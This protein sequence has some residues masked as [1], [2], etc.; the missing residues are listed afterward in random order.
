MSTDADS[1]YTII[2]QHAIYGNF[3]APKVQEI[4]VARGEVLELLRP[5]DNGRVQTVHSTHVFGIIRSLQAFRFPGSHE[6]YIIVGSDSGR[7]VILKFSAEKNM[8]L[9]IHQETFGKSGCRRIVPGEYL[10]VDPKGRACLIGALEKQKFVYVLNRDSDAQLTISSPLDA[11]KSYHIVFDIVG[12]DMGFDNPQF[13]AIELDYGEVDVDPTGEAAAEATKQLVIY[14]LDLGLNS[15]TRKSA[16]DIDSGAN[17][18][19]PVPG[20]ADGGPGGVLVCCENFLL[21][22]NA[23][24]PEL[25]A[26]IPRRA[27]LPLDKSVLITA[28]ATLK[29][30]SRFFTFLQTEYGDL[31][32]VTMTYDGSTVTELKMKYFDT[33]PPATSI[34]ILRK[35]FLFAASEFGDHYLY[36]FEGLGDDEDAVESSSHNVKLEN[37]MSED[38]PKYH[39]MR[40]EP[41]FPLR[42]L[43]QIDTISSVSPVIDMKV[44]N[45]LKEETPQIYCACGRGTRSS[46]RVLRPGLSVTEVASSVLKANAT[47]VFTMK[48][49]MEDEYDTYVVVSF[50]HSTLIL[51]VGETVEPT[52]ETGFDEETQTLGAQHMH[53][54]SLSQITPTGI[55]H[56]KQSGQV[57]EWKAPERRNVTKVASN[58]RQVAIALAGGEVL[59]FEMT[60]QG[61]LIETER[62][63][64][65]GDVSSLSLGD[66][67][68][69]SLRNRYLAVGSYD[70]TVR[71]LSLDPGDG[72]KSLN[73]QML[74]DTPESLL[75]LDESEHHA[76]LHLQIGLANG[77]LQRTDVDR[78][79]GEM[80]DS[81]TRFLGAKQ[82]TLCRVNVAGKKSMLA[83]SSRPWIGYTDQGKYSIAPISYESLNY[84]APFSTEQCPE[85]FV[86]VT[87]NSLRVISIDRL[88]QFFNELSIPL[89]YTPRKLIIHPD[90]STLVTIESDTQMKNYTSSDG[91]SSMDVDGEADKMNQIGSYQGTRGEWASCIRIVDPST[92]T[93]LHSVELDENEAAISAAIAEFD[94]AP[95]RGLLLCV[96]TTKGLSFNPRRSEGNYIRTYAFAEDGKS[97]SLIHKTEV[98]AIPRALVQFKGKLLAG[99]GASV[100][101][102]DVGKKRLLRKCEY[103]S[104]PT[105]V[106]TLHTTGSRIYVGDAYE[107]V[108]FMKYKK[109]ENKLYIFADDSI[110]RHITAVCPLD[111]DTVAA[112]DKFGNLTVLRLPPEL[113]AAVEEDPT[114]GKYAGDISTGAPN[115]LQSIANFHVGEIITSIQRSTLQDHGKE[116]MLYTTLN[117]TVGAVHAFSS[118]DSIDFF[119]HLEMHMRQE[120]P[121]L[122][123]RDHL[124]FRSAYIPVK[125]VVDGDLCSQFGRLPIDTQK[126]VA[127][128]LDRTPTEVLKKIEDTMNLIV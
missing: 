7:I 64:L 11:H 79:T 102:F 14:E 3:S 20:L 49:N 81:R 61:N 115:K 9:K 16:E 29:Q 22:R 100:K 68:E 10:A 75:L 70:K 74:S 76:S 41:R 95:D 122:L 113:S 82:P 44:A 87:S 66:I 59:Y 110:P 34:C 97:L 43:D 72:M 80:T 107:S 103:K 90:H 77:L 5:D 48:K 120:S 71:V 84:A 125:S 104:L 52:S 99:I 63:E 118:R 91:D 88:G 60:P 33:I 83:L 36:Q 2:M 78:V 55:R 112:A 17:K 96:G 126:T 106:A 27:D 109:A 50:S 21:Y 15:V 89:K 57:T 23:D 25:R 47:A 8:F 117:G 114:A 42:N 38:G 105:D 62:K 35:G 18:L 93:S 111:Y 13:A 30:K 51:Q 26:A 69:G 6:D 98:D 73:M 85:G 67:P 119:Q 46:L 31:F 116:I 128:E 124:A 28:S 40:F 108:H 53:D 94:S 1:G 4:V 121:P 24:H 19:I 86:A 37:G 32:R 58:E 92:L 39:P 127:T 123:G 65:G 56:V 12:L 45:L 101:L 54:G